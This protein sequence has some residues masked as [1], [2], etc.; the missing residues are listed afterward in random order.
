MPRRPE[1]GNVQLYPDR[2]LRKSDR[3]GYVL[4][5]YCPIRC[6]RIRRN[7]G[8]RDRREARRIQRECQERL[9]NGQY[10]ATGG[11]ISATHV[12]IAVSESRSLEREN[13]TANGPAWQDC[14][15]RYL[16]QR[17]PRVRDDSLVD[18]V[19]RLG[20]VE[21][22]LEGGLRDANRPEGLLMSEVATL[23][24]LEYLQERLLAGDE[25]RYDARSPNTVNSLMGAVMAFIR[26]CHSRGWVAAVPAL[27]K[28]DVDEVMK[29][30][31]ITEAEFQRM[32]DATEAVVGTGSAESWI[33]VLKVLWESGF[34]T[35]DLMDFSWG[36]QRHIHPV[37]PTQKGQYPTIVVPS[38]QK[39]GLVQ[40]IPLLPGLAE[41]LEEVP[42]KLRT[43]WIANPTGIEFKFCG[44]EDSFRPS[45]VDLRKLTER[46]SNVAIG[47]ACGVS[48]AAVRKWLRRS[49]I[50]SE[51]PRP[52]NGVVPANQVQRL[53][54]RAE[55]CPGDPVRRATERLTKERVS[56]VIGLIGM[57]AGIV[58]QMEDP[59][60]QKRKKFASAHDI[61]RGLAQRL[62]N[63][64]VS[65]E[66]LKVVMRHKDFATTERHYG[67]LRSAHSAAAEISTR[68]T[69]SADSSAFVGGIKKAHD[70]SAEEVMI[71]KSLLARL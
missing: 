70:L 54:S 28:L 1:L 27:E 10:L 16:E 22:I 21:R 11:A 14:Y 32:L 42:Q 4:K 49:G 20:I 8:T 5:F 12:R 24:M 71:L 47:A 39:N 17:R 58:V 64:G 62:I 18:I 2:P 67:A 29:G 69:P 23:D 13:D 34:R 41:L 3:N 48:E 37:W 61:R 60:V 38:S 50:P 53:R 26:F 63:A 40:E 33:F 31:P 56:R 7:C 35:G 15:Q 36:D 52:E 55:R 19:S 43:G 6:Q 66:T 65:A 9:L 51:R 45:E 46:Y 59:R 68:L 44:R 57:E 30:R 25:C